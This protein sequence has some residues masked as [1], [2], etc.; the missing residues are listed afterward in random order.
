MED[1]HGGGPQGDFIG[2]L[3]YLSQS[4][5]NCETIDPKDKFKY[6]NDLT[7][8]EI[9]NLLSIGMSNFNAKMNVSND[10]PIDNG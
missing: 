6:V 7:A 10:I 2:L 8:L 5:D 4:Y 9:V 3:K 1:N